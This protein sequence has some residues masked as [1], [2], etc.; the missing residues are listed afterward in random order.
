ME[1]SLTKLYV[2]ELRATS[3]LSTLSGMQLYYRNKIIKNTVSVRCASQ[4]TRE[5]IKPSTHRTILLICGKSIRTAHN[6]H[7]RHLKQGE[8]CS[9]LFCFCV[10]ELEKKG[11]MTHKSIHLNLEESVSFPQIKGQRNIPDE[12]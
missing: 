10:R 2:M 8:G 6:G 12:L 4:G 9:A 11:F 1:G 7:C 5:N 3:F